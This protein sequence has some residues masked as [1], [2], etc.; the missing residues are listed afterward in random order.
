MMKAP[1][2]SL[3]L[4]LV[5]ATTAFAGS[6]LICFPIETGGAATIPF[7]DDAFTKDAGYDLARRT[8]TLCK[9]AQPASRLIRRPDYA[10]VFER[11]AEG[12]A[13]GRL[14][15]GVCVIGH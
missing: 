8:I 5:F 7:G 9:G 3:A 11:L 14:D 13:G 4:S 15:G 6:P 2:A 1:F 10:A 12:R